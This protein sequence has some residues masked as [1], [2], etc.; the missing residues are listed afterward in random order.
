[1]ALLVGSEPAAAAGGGG[2]AAE[3]DVEASLVIQ[4]DHQ[5]QQQQGDGSDDD[6]DSG[7][8]GFEIIPATHYEEADEMDGEQ[9]GKDGEAEKAAAEEP[10]GSSVQGGDGPWPRDHRPHRHFPRRRGRLRFGDRD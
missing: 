1:M 6:S 3:E 2:G 4:G 5:Q 7:S 9:R 10:E 8:D